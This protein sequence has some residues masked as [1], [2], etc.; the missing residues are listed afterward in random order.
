MVVTE[1]EAA[2]AA[3]A[4]DAAVAAGGLSGLSVHPDVKQML[5]EVAGTA[6]VMPG[7][8]AAAAAAGVASGSQ[9][10]DMDAGDGAAL[11]AAAAAGGGVEVLWQSPAAGPGVLQPAV[12][13]V[14]KVGPAAAA[15]VVA[16]AGVVL[17]QMLLQYT[18][19]VPVSLNMW[20]TGTA[21]HQCGCRFSLYASV[22]TSL[23]VLVYA[24]ADQCTPLPSSPNLSFGSSSSRC[25]CKCKCFTTPTAVGICPAHRPWL[26]QP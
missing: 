3:A 2:A 11:A 21:Q 24:A 5:V 25:K 8:A 13:L 22:L 26:L 9:D 6:E 16:A 12:G 19:Q 15:V 18:P 17:Q 1:A 23:L 4:N 20:H 10:V 14:A 7:A